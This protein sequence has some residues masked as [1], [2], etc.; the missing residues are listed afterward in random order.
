MHES[1][2]G[3]LKTLWDAD[4]LLRQYAGELYANEVPERDADGELVSVPYTYVEMGRTHFNWHFGRSHEEVTTLDFCVFA[5]GLRN[6]ELAC[7]EVQ[8]A[9]TKQHLPFTTPQSY[10]VSLLPTDYA[11]HSENVRYKTGDLI[12]RAEIRYSCRVQRHPG[13]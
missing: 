4:G 13:G 2:L 6:A 1:V 10:T 5:V 12:Y 8:R 3:A 11:I 7:G 9:L